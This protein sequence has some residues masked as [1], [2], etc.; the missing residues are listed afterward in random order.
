M[1]R[2][3]FFN[4]KMLN[5]GGVLAAASLEGERLQ[6]WIGNH[7]DGVRARALFHPSELDQ[8]SA[9]LADQALEHYP[10]SSYAKV[11]RLLAQSMADALV[12]V[13]TRRAR[14]AR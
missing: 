7:E 2:S 13:Q 3:L 6:V 4:L 11:K 1:Q 9:W 12:I 8:A 5:A 10:D 14:N